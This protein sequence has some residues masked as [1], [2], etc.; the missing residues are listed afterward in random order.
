MGSVQPRERR[1]SE[2]YFPSGNKS[3]PKQVWSGGVNYENY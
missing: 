3:E 2:E 1:N